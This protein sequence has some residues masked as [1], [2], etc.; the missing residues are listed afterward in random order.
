MTEAGC[1]P[2]PELAFFTLLSE[3]FGI[4]YFLDVYSISDNKY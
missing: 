1:F 3:L 2:S 4:T